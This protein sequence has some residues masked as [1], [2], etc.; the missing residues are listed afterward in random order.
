MGLSLIG[1]P[2]LFLTLS[3]GVFINSDHWQSS[4]WQVLHLW[5]EKNI[6]IGQSW[7][8]ETFLLLTEESCSN[9]LCTGMH[10]SGVFLLYIK[11]YSLL[12]MQTIF[13]SEHL[14]A[15]LSSSEKWEYSWN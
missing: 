9:K 4:E 11:S 5:V 3:H 7:D 15:S 13:L 14:R 2:L 10:G 8:F 6:W 12:K 1:L